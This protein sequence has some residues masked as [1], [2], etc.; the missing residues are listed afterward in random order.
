MLV[1]VNDSGLLVVTVKNSELW[2]S[3][4]GATSRTISLKDV[5]L[6]GLEKLAPLREILLNGSF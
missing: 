3:L 6:S 5:D 1:Q 2:N 4:D